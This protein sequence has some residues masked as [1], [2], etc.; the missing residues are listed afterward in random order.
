MLAEAPHL[1][2]LLYRDV[3]RSRIGEEEGGESDWYQ[4][5]VWGVRDGKFTS[6]FSRTYI[7]ALAHVPDAP[8]VTAEMWQALDL[9]AEIADRHALDMTLR[10]GDI[11]FL[12]N[13]V[14]YHSRAEFEDDPDR[15]LVRSLSRIWLCAPHR[16]LPASHHVLWQRTEAG[17]I[18][19]GIRQV[20][21]A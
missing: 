10:R 20:A 1:C 19:G 18:R 11:Q 7:E 8:T 17:Q 5:P 16:S 15:G 14:I 2:K 6:H 4:L 13:H 12:N 21:G 3:P 9:L